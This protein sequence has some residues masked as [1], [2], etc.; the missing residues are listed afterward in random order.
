MIEK[1][2]IKKDQEH[3]MLLD[4]EDGWLLDILRAFLHKGYACTTIRGN[5]LN[6]LN[7]K[8]DYTIEPKYVKGTNKVQINK[9]FHRLL[10]EIHHP[11]LRDN[12]NLQVDH[13]NG[14]RLDN[15]KEN[16]R[17]VTPQQNNMNRKPLKNSTSKYKGVFW[18]KNRNK[19][20]VLIMIGDKSRYLGRYQ[21][22]REAALAYDKAAKKLFGEYA[23]LNFGEEKTC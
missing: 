16:L 23:H 22:E 17:L 3:T 19:W 4:D 5:Q 11:E 15:R 10:M 2:I 14:N 13:I 21:D 7:E 20:L 12:P 18:D 8:I 1:K 9:L 6:N